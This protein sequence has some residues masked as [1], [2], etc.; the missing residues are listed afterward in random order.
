MRL[1]VPLVVSQA[2]ETLML[3]T[4]RVFLSRLGPEAM[5][6]SMGGGLTAFMMSTF[7]AGLTGYTNAL[8][9]QYYGARQTSRCGAATGQ[10]LWISFGAF[11][12]LMACL[13][14]GPWLFTAVGVPE[15]QLALQRTYF[16]YAMVGAGIGLARGS[17]A[18]FFSGIGR[19]SIVMVAAA[20]CLLVNATVGYALIFGKLGLPALGIDGAGIGLVVAGL[21]GLLVLGAAY[22]RRRYRLRYGTI[23]GLSLHRPTMLQLLRLGSPAGLEFFL[24]L[25][26]F[27]LLVMV[28]HSRGPTVA[29]AVTVA[30]N[31]DMV[32]FIPLVGINVSVASLVG[33]SMGAGEPDR[34]HRTTVSALKL[35]SGYSAA[36]I[37]LY[38]LAPGLLVGIFLQPEHHGAQALA[39]FMVRLVSVYVFADALTL[40]FGGALRGAGD[41]FVTM[42]LSV[43]VHWLLLAGTVLALHRFHLSER[44]AW[45]ILVI[46]VWTAAL[47][48]FLR[49]RAGRWRSLRVVEPG[50]GDVEQAWS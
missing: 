35:V 16:T 44:G 14:L 41:T 50:P 38:S 47:A 11:P 4:D 10:A 34:A 45:M 12:V 42:C 27:N 33:R 30:F 6:A 22:L 39:V 18:S 21:S 1:A 17:L 31:W 9:A 13:P 36:I 28:F 19:T 15:G 2:L 48:F 24:N 25:L 37:L 49:Y 20:T 5:A 43:G 26:A 3:M 32:S 46:L 7:F 8:V 40:V 23:R 29:A